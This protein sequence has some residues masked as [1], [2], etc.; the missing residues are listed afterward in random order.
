M[1]I[2]DA[3][4]M[5]NFIPSDTT[6]KLRQGY[7]K[8]IETATRAETIFA[9]AV[10]GNKHLLF[11]ADGRINK[12]NPADKSVSEIASGYASNAWQYKLYKQRIIAVG[13]QNLPFTYDG[14]TITANP[15]TVSQDPQYHNHPR[16]AF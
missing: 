15:F 14:T 11:A 10:A 16:R 2:T 4:I 7:T 8:Y 6:L 12:I 13:A 3:I 1:P 9:Y 5:D